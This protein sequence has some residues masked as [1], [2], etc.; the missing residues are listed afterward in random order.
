MI[1]GFPSGE[2]APY[3]SLTRAEAATLLS[4]F[5]DLTVNYREVSPSALPS[6][7]ESFLTQ[8]YL[9]RDANQLFGGNYYSAAASGSGTNIL[10]KLL[11]NAS[12]VDF[13][14]YPGDPPAAHWWDGSSDPQDR[15]NGSFIQ[16]DAM[17]VSWVARNILHISEGDLN[18]LATQGETTRQFYWLDGRYYA[19]AEGVGGFFQQAQ[20]THAL[21]DGRRYYLTYDIYQNTGSSGKEYTGTRYAVMAREQIDGKSYWTLY[22]NTPSPL[23]VLTE[24]EEPDAAWNPA[25]R[26]FVLEECYRAAGQSYGAGT[27]SFALHDMNGD[28]TPELLINSGA[29]SLAGMCQYVYTWDGDS[30]TY[31]GALTQTGASYYTDPNG[32]YPGVRLWRKNGAPYRVLLR[33]EKRETAEHSGRHG[34][35]RSDSDRRIHLRAHD[36]NRG[37]GAV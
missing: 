23:S 22:V 15:Y 24:P 7:A 8:F 2:Y 28:G 6:G 3:D 5:A 19:Y 10:A 14:L 31:A 36:R 11:S 27:V 25:Y 18:I 17:Q 4:Q 33:P 9:Y 13:S 16:F 26:A 1:A 21:T 34:H 37:H 12:C 20:V 35:D 32:V 29:E 30:V